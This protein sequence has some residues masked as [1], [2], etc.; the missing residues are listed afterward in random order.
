MDSMF[1]DCTS[2]RSVNMSGLDMRNLTNA[3]SMFHNCSALQSIDLTPLGNAAL[4][5]VSSRLLWGCRSLST[6]ILKLNLSSW[7]SINLPEPEPSAVPNATGRWLDESGEYS[8]G[9]F[10][11][12]VG[13]VTL[14]AEQRTETPSHTTSKPS[15]NNATATVGTEIYAGKKLTPSSVTVKLNGKTLRK[16]TDYIVSCAG[17]ESVGSYK[18]T[19]TGKG[20]YTGSKIVTFIINPKGTSVSKLIKAKR[21]FTVKWK[22]PSKTA[23]KQIA[24]YQIRFATSKS[25]K[26]AKIN[27]V[28]AA[29]TAGKKCSFKVSKLK[30]NKKYYVQVRTYK[31]TGGKTYYST[32]SKAKT[33]KTKK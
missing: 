10:R 14:R 19:I 11:A 1:W 9:G 20:A 15:L 31:K 13:V 30:G 3:S 17:G 22:K 28:K 27:T 8:S 32:W 23:L 12:Y 25:M 7:G 26:D 6:I 29:S 18:V 33:I 16:D 5:K 2:L 24:G 4:E 21:G